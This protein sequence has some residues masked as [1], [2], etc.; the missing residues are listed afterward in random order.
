MKNKIPFF[1][2]LLP[3]FLVFLLAGCQLKEN[4]SM[5]SSFT[6]EIITQTKLE[7]KTDGISV[8][9]S[10]ADF[11]CDLKSFKPTLSRDTDT[12]TISLQGNETTQRC[13]QKFSSEIKGIEPGDYWLKVIYQKGDEARQVVYQQFTVTK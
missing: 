13:P 5:Q 11:S 10:F 6:N 7:I 1:V 4:Y 3:C 12:F 9:V 2:F 8:E